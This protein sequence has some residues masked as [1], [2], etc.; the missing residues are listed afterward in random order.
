[1]NNFAILQ[2]LAFE[3][4]KAFQ[5]LDQRPTFWWPLL[6]V[7]LAAAALNCWYTAVVDLEWLADLQLRNNP[8]T[9]NMTSAEIE[10]MARNA[11][12]S[13]GAAVVQSG[14][15]TVLAMALIVLL[16]GLYYWVA[17]KVTN[18]QRSYRHWLSLS[19]WTTVPT[20]LAFLASAVV[21]LTASSS[22]ISQADLQP[23]SLNALVVHRQSGD[24]G[25]SLF[26]S[27]NIVQLLSLYLA[28]VGVHVWSRRSWLFS[29]VFA[30]LP[31]VLTYGAWAFFSLR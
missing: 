4:R 10:R 6:L 13:R 24:P 12:S 3:P 30:V 29:T 26:T 28:V 9:R 14:V 25:Y 2:A 15:G 20:L 16:S 19:A 18:V 5:A 23:L 8:L 21:L 31:F 22:Q 11:A 17:G 1:M 7:A 27:L